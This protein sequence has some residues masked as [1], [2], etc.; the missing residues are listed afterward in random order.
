MI[1]KALLG[2]ALFGVAIAEDLT[3]PPENPISRFNPQQQT[4]S[5]SELEAKIL[6]VC[7]M[8]IEV[9]DEVLNMP[10]TVGERTRCVNDLKQKGY[11]YSDDYLYP[12]LPYQYTYINYFYISGNN[13]KACYLWYHPYYFNCYQTY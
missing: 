3:N 9:Y 1:K 13:V 4:G 2:L 10:K 6:N 7:G 5:L 11:Y 12:L 8:I